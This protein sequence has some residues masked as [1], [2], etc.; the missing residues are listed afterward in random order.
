MINN[1]L[2]HYGSSAASAAPSCAW[3]TTTGTPTATGYRCC[4]LLNK[5][6]KNILNVGDIPHIFVH[7]EKE[8][9]L[10]MVRW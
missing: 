4:D 5:L 8:K 1:T 10:K 9:K 6:V 2:V 3:A 7:A